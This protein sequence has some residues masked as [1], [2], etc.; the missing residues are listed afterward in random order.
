MDQNLKTELD[1]LLVAVDSVLK[2]RTEL[3]EKFRER[4]PS[5]TLA[6]AEGAVGGIVKALLDAAKLTAT[7]AGVSL[8]EQKQFELRAALH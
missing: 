7:E 6:M 3:A 4:H 2:R 1:A 8:A 5:A